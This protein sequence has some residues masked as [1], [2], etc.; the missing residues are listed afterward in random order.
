MKG[1]VP[2]ERQSAG[3]IGEGTAQLRGQGTGAQDQP[4]E[5]APKTR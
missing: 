1:A 3:E 4:I 2:G 5:Q